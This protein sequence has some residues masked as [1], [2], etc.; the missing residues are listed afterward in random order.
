MRKLTW[1]ELPID[2][3]MLNRDYSIWNKFDE[4]FF[5]IRYYGWWIPEKKYCLSVRNDHVGDP[6][7]RIKSWHLTLEDAKKAA[8]KLFRREIKR[9]LEHITS[10][11]ERLSEVENTLRRM[12][13][14]R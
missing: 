9:T 2:T 14:E 4:F 12:T 8:E 6:D 3:D 11:K 1:K 13:N 5:Q 7:L 10:E